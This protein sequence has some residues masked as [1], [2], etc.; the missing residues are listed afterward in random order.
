MFQKLLI[1]FLFIC[2]FSYAQSNFTSYIPRGDKMD[3]LTRGDLNKDGIDDVVMVTSAKKNDHQTA[4]P[5]TLMIFFGKPNGTYEL[6][7]QSTS[8]LAG[9]NEYAYCWFEGVSIKNGVLTIE[10][11]YLRG[12][13]KHLFRYQHGGFYLIG[14]S[15]ATGDA[16]SFL[17]VEYNLSTG[18]W[19]GRHEF[20][21]TNE[22]INRT[23]TK[24]MGTLP[25][26]ETYKLFTVEVDGQLL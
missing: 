12:G 23:G 8:V 26:I 3:T 11:E 16:G 14:A 17:S 19:V 20:D 10:H 21:E 5:K 2:P 6:N 13:C 22:K 7:T 15:T 4:T 1:A 9:Q 18:K 25:R 24:K